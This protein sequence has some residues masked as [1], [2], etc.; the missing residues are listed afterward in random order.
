MDE[1]ASAKKKKPI[2]KRWWFW[3]IAVFILFGIGSAM[4]EP[5]DNQIAKTDNQTDQADTTST[6]AATTT[7]SNNNQKPS[8]QQISQPDQPA[9]ATPTYQL[10]ATYSGSGPKQFE[11]FTITGSRFKIEYSCGGDL[12]QA[13]LYKDNGSLKALVMNSGDPVSDVTIQYGKGSY[14]LD[15]NSIGSYSFKVYDYK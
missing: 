9:P 10:I 12:C 15:S 7:K 14:Y 3:V 13:F 6:P 5:K 8:N 2:Y 11:P 1:T 4:S